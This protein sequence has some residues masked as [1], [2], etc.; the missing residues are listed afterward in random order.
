MPISDYIARMRKKIGTELL[1]VPSAAAV[2]RDDGGRILVQRRSDNGKWSLPGGAID[3]GEAPAQAIV[4]EVW[5][6]TG[7]RVRPVA[8]L[9][10]LGSFRHT[11]PQGDVVDVVITVFSCVIVGGQLQ[12]RDGEA[13]ELRFF[14]SQAMPKLMLT[15]PPDVFVDKTRETYFEWKEE[16]LQ[17]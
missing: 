8:I 6:E 3:P 2:V 5:E 7:L 16:W 15:Y 1:Q 13:L 4:R 14:D 17:C 9:G 12:C 10:V 11:Y